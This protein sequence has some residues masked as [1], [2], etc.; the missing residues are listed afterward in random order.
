M[1]DFFNIPETAI[2]TFEAWSNLRV[3]IWDIDKIHFLPYLAPVRI[4]FDFPHCLALRNSE[5]HDKCIFF[6]QTYT[7]EEIGKHPEGIS[8]VC[9]AGLVEW[10]IPIFLEH[11]VVSILYAG[12]RT[13]ISSIPIDLT[14]P[15]PVSTNLPWDDDLHMPELV[16]QNEAALFMEGLRQLAARLQL[17]LLEAQ[18]IVGKPPL[19]SRKNDLISR[20]NLILNFIYEKHTEQISLADLATYLHLSESRT[21]HVVKEACGRTF[22]TLLVEARIRSATTLL[23]HSQLSV[24]DV[25]HRCGILDSSRFFKLFK[26]ETGVSPSAYRQQHWQLDRR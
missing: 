10:C 13:A 19:L 6:E 12:H 15:Q 22:S 26:Q 23:R 4:N 1:T 14:D 18:T 2:I 24:S 7:F 11:Q 20:R 25:A 21:S 5:L 3:F 9:H 17:W 16:T 8:K